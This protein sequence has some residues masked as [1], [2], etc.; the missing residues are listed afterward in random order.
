MNENNKPIRV[1]SMS[2]ISC[3]VWKRDDMVSF[4]FQKSYKDKEDNWKHTTSFNA[5]D[6]LIISSLSESI[7]KK[8]LLKLFTPK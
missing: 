7:A 3:S 6:L 8:E 1:Y 2:N 5:K 4:T